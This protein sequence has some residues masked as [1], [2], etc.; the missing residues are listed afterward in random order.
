MFHGHDKIRV[1]VNARPMNRVHLR[2]MG[3]YVRE[4]VDRGARSGQVQWMLLA[5]RPDL[6]F[7]K[8]DGDAFELN[9]FRRQG[10]RFH[11]WEQVSLP[12]NATTWGADV[13]HCTATSLPWWQPV[14]TVVTLHDT[15]PWDSEDEGPPDGWYLGRLLP[16]AFKRCAAIITISESSRRDILR[17]W[18]MLEEKL[19]V[20]PHGI[21]DAYL[22]ASIDSRCG[23]LAEIGVRR[24]Y[25]LYMGGS[26]PRK[27]L[28]WAIRVL[29]GLADSRVSLVACGVEKATQ[30]KTRALI[31]DELR[32]QVHFTP[33]VAESTMP[34]LFQN[35]VAVLY[36]TLYEGFGFPALEAQAVGTPVLFSAL[37]SL[38]ELQGP[39]A[40]VLPPHDL[41]AWVSACRHLVAARGDSPSPDQ[42]SRSWA[43][44][45]SW[46][47]CAERHFE[48]YRIV[49]AHRGHNG[50]NQ[51]P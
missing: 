30:E 19:H 46:D 22:E 51:N 29:E 45:F 1:A 24:P 2:G 20:I 9:V 50:R 17:T 36:P 27:R 40:I 3:K 48:I 18:P 39:G 7:H 8:P 12:R 5:D 15:I 47:V 31:R 32:P 34:S 41:G 37:G 33:F 26:N 35:A 16:S 49:A 21:N 13:L 14:P 44:G 10:D 25:L 28:D 38:A 42:R 6:P 43:K 4:V 11:R 23:T